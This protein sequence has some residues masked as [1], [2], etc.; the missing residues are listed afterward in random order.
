M[1]YRDADG[2]AGLLVEFLGFAVRASALLTAL[3]FVA[4]LFWRYS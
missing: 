1:N 2:V 3:I 4:A